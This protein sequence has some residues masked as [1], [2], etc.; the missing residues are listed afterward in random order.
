MLTYLGTALQQTSNIAH[1]LRRGILA[2]MGWMDNELVLFEV[3][4]FITGLSY[5][6]TFCVL[7]AVVYCHVVCVSRDHGIR[8][9]IAAVKEDLPKEVLRHFFAGTD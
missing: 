6:F 5:I 3:Y 9:S 1:L 7:K 2:V 8:L 4:K